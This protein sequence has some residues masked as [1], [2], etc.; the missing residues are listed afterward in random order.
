M[1]QTPPAVLAEAAAAPYALTS[2]AACDVIEAEIDELDRVL[3]P[4]LDRTGVDRESSIAIDLA[5]S[6]IGDVIG[7]PF[8][9][10][11]RRMSGAERRDQDLADA[12]LAGMVRRGFLRGA[13]TSRSCAVLRET[14]K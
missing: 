10:V 2:D 13:A 4:D 8:R 5:T 7:L 11:V 9:G 6:A 12:V 14:P 1:R 3:G